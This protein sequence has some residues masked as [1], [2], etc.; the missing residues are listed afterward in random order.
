MA[1]SLGFW[2]AGVLSLGITQLCSRA[3]AESTSTPTWITGGANGFC[4]V[5]QLMADSGQ[6]GLNRKDLVS[7]HGKEKCF[8]ACSVALRLHFN[9]RISFFEESCSAVQRKSP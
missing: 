2:V 9:F 3:C 7:E 5:G 4:A 8:C 6:G 1:V